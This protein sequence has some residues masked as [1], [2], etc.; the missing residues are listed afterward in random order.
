MENTGLS[1]LSNVFEHAIR[2]GRTT[3]NPCLAVVTNAQDARTREPAPWEVECLRSLAE[4]PMGLMMDLEAVTGWRVMN[5]VHLARAQ[6][7][8]DGIR[9]RSKRGQRRLWEWTPEL[10]RITAEASSLP[11]ATAFPASPIF[12]TRTGRAYS[13]SG[14]YRA[15]NR[16]IER[17]NAKLAACDVPLRIEDLHFHDLRSKAHDDAIDAGREG[18]ELLGNTP[19]V[20]EEHYSRRER[21]IRALR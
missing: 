14:F 15:W 16:L 8:A 20:A 18:N 7:T 12:P 6:L 9:V 17:A 10:R 13:Y 5:I 3:Y 21:R 1:V 2:T 4:E 11:Q 19:R